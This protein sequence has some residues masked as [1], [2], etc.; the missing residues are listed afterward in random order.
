VSV[1]TTG[2]SGAGKDRKG[3]GQGRNERQKSREGG[4]EEGGSEKNAECGKKPGSW[5]PG[6]EG[7]GRKEE[8]EEKA[9]K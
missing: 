9:E 4:S 7:G 5:N 1:K 3:E 2:E 6:I 8:G